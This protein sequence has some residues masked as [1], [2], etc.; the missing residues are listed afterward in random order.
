[1]SKFK[2]SIFVLLFI[3][4]ALFAQHNQSNIVNTNEQNNTQTQEPTSTFGAVKIHPVHPNILF[5]S[6]LG[7]IIK[8][9]DGGINWNTIYTKTG[10]WVTEFAMPSPNPDIILAATN[11][12]LLRSINGGETW[13]PL[14][15]ETPAVVENKSNPK[16]YPANIEPAKEMDFSN[17]VEKTPAKPT[18]IKR[19]VQQTA[20]RLPES[21]DER[22]FESTTV[23]SPKVTIAPNPLSSNDI[24]RIETNVPGEMKFR[25]FNGN[26]QALKVVKFVKTGE[27]DLDGI[28]NGT[29]FYRVENKTFKMGGVLLVQ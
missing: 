6:T 11:Q 24:A 17:I 29:Y 13:S 2:L 28:P 1:M 22:E 19:M 15:S 8:S 25:L 5:V 20:A 27:I 10:L 26:G 16:N 14:F 4:F 7:K 9:T 3:N 21:T 23:E 18:P 12:G